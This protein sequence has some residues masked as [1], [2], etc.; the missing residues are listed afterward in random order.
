[1]VRQATDCQEIDTKHISEK[2]VLARYIKSTWNLVTRK[3]V[4]FLRSKDVIKH[5]KNKT[6]IANTHMRRWPKSFVSGAIQVKTMS[7]YRCTPFELVFVSCGCY[8]NFPLW[9]KM[10]EIDSPTV[11]KP[12]VQD[13][14][15]TV[16]PETGDSVL[17]L[18]F[19]VAVGAPWLVATSLLHL[20]ISSSA[21]CLSVLWGH[22]GWHLGSTWLI[23]DNLTSGYPQLHL[24]IR[25]HSQTLGIRMWAYVLGSPHSAH[26]IAN[27]KQ[28]SS[29]CCFAILGSHKVSGIVVG[30]AKSRGHSKNIWQLLIK[31]NR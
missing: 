19:L 14:S 7:R 21:V 4:Q 23:Q 2:G 8:N 11:W 27:P 15:A 5:F 26:C 6:Y 20:H 28:N 12:E 3:A 18:P 16:S 22:L 13:Q 10:T 31:W 17:A 24:Q 29:H 9:L 25:S 1:M 30:S